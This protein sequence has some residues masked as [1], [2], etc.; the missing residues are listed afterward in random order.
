[1][2]KIKSIIL[3]S[4]IRLLPVTFSIALTSPKVTRKII[5]LLVSLR[6]PLEVAFRM[7]LTIIETWK[8]SKPWKLTESLVIS[9]KER[10]ERKEGIHKG[11][12]LLFKL[13]IFL[14]K[15]FKISLELL[16][17]LLSIWSILISIC[18][19]P[20]FF[21]PHLIAIMYFFRT[22]NVILIIRIGSASSRSIV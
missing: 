11:F 17:P 3:V 18:T 19:Y 21:F 1:M 5:K 8:I 12:K 13:F 14:L 15:H 7:T 22:N 10:R 2:G 16:I 4:T 6:I 20:L 9:E